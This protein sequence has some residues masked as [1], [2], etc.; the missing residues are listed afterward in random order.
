MTSRFQSFGESPVAGVFDKAASAGRESPLSE[1]Y[2]PGAEQVGDKVLLWNTD[3]DPEDEHYTGFTRAKFSSI[4][5]TTTVD[6]NDSWSENLN[7]Y[8]L[9]IWPV[10]LGMPVWLTQA[11]L[12]NWTGLIHCTVEWATEDGG[13]WEAS[14]VFVNALGGTGHWHNCTVECA[15]VDCGQLPVRYGAT[16]AHPLTANQPDM[17]LA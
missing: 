12:E 16:T 14:R 9:I 6:D 1:R 13:G 5:S 3:W 11:S 17:A 15:M 7:D 8:R 2:D 4:Y 10:P